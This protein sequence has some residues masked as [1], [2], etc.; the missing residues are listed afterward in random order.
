MDLAFYTNFT[1]SLGTQEAQINTLQQQISTGLAVQTPDQ[2]PA[3]YES[4]ALANDQVA[5]LSTESQTQA[6]IQVQ[7]G[8][9]DSAYQET[10]NLLNNVQAVLEAA[11]NGTSSSQN[12]AAFATQ[13]KSAQQQ[14]LSIANVTASN[15]SYLFGGSRG[16]VAPFQ[17]NSSGSIVYFGDGGQ[18]QAAI[19][20]DSTA[21]TIANGDVFVSGLAGD[22]IASVTADSSNTGTGQLISNGP[23]NA[24]AALAFQQGTAAITV[25]FST[26]ATTGATDYTATQSGSTVASGTLATSGTNSVQLGGEDFSIT[27]APAAGDS[28]TISPS[29]PVSA[30]ALL[31]SLYK[32]LAAATNTPAAVAQTNQILNQ[33]LASVAQ[34]QA[35]LVAAQAQNGVTLQAVANAGTSNTAQSTTLQTAVQN[36]VGVNTPVAITQLNETLT[37]LQ[38]ALKTFATAQQLSLFNYI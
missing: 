7:L 27:G 33:G 24:A 35:G 36:A 12:L 32:A 26:D 28:F 38:A 21:S 5:A 34:Y 10:N 15:G 16:T 25:S 14:L 22:G 29:R 37:A 18:S 23:V 30:F 20:P 9:V 2:N 1:N 13:I 19:T 31:G 17:T 6:S 8:S 11:L 3:A 4:A